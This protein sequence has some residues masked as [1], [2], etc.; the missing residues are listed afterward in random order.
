MNLAY[1]STIL[2]SH[3]SDDVTITTSYY[4]RKL[5]AMS[6]HQLKS[7][8]AAGAGLVASLDSDINQVLE[9]L[10]LDELE[11]SL[12]ARELEVLTQI[13][14]NLSSKRKSGTSIPGQLVEL[15]RQIFWI[16]GLKIVES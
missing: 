4:I 5:I 2:S 13:H 11:I 9:S 8:L 14:R 16:L 1:S 15:E 3:V 7:V 12:M 6:A 10:Y